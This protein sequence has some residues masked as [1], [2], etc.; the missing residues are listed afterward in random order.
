ME[1]T[2]VRWVYF[3][4]FIVLGLTVPASAGISLRF[5]PAFL[6]PA[7][8]G[9][10]VQ[11]AIVLRADAGHSFL[12]T[13]LQGPASVR[14]SPA[15]RSVALPAMSD[16]PLFFRLTFSADLESATFAA[17]INQR[18]V[19][20]LDLGSAYDLEAIGW[21]GQL[22]RHGVGED[23]G[24]MDPDYDDRGWT[25]Y[26]LPAMWNDTGV[27]WL[28]AHLHVP[29][30]WRG[31][32][33]TVRLAA[34][35]DR[36]VC[37]W[38]GHRIGATDGWDLPREYPVDD[39]YIRF[40]AE[41]VLC[42]AIHNLMYGG[43]IYRSPNVTG[44][45]LPD[46]PPRERARLAPPGPVAPPLPLRA[47]RVENG[48]LLY[49]DGG[50]VALWGVN[51]YPQSWYPY[52]HLKRLGIDPHVAIDHDLEDML[53]MGVEVIRIHVF[54]REISD[55]TGTLLDNEHLEL[56]DYL[57]AEGTRRGLYFFFTPIAWWWGP[58]QNP[59]SFSARTPKEF[60]W[61]DESAIAAQTRYVQQWLEHPNRYTG[62]AYKDE[63]AI[64]VFEI[65]NEPAYLDYNMLFDATKS[66]YATDEGQLLPFKRRMIER[67]EKWC[68]ERGV[69]AEKRLFP[70][71]RYHVLREYL[72]TMYYTMR[73][74]GAQQPIGVSL[75]DTTGHDDLIAAIAD[76]PCE[77][78]VTGLYTGTWDRV[79]DGVNYLEQT[80]NESLDARLNRKARV[81]YEFDGIK[82]FGRYL[83]PAFARRFRHMGVQVCCMFQYDS[84][85][86]AEWNVDWDAHYLNWLYTPNKA[87]SFQIAGLLFRH[88]ERGALYPDTGDEQRWGVC[89]VS[90]PRNTSVYVGE[91]RVFWA[92]PD[93]GWRPLSLPAQ[94]EQVVAVGDS[95]YTCYEGCGAYTLQLDYED[96]GAT[97]DINPDAV[98]VGDPWHP[99]LE[100]SAVVLRHATYPF[101]ILVEGVKIRTVTQTE[102]EVSVPCSDNTF[103]VSPGRYKLTW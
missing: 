17:F 13:A 1:H 63:P 4:P 10:Q 57:I 50:E 92:A 48:V 15:T 12:T 34:V 14:I 77:M 64:C 33:T 40:G 22:D 75:F 27:T 45:A 54:D 80:R 11:L 39:G 51:Y 60:M 35:D 25:P 94:P 28:R 7:K 66:Y 58:D 95:P 41:N 67:W 102:G 81:V 71:F 29:E 24:W 38:N 87:V 56:L 5:L 90:F 62:R 73:A 30:T 49:E 9:A 69:R 59:E 19:A 72:E 103:C 31:R 101:T 93:D 42:V 89:A 44:V 86:T 8:A 99:S 74:T 32:G 2:A 26:V 68:E 36:D 70:L 65:M 79:G 78:V 46:P 37:Y 55:A 83:Y 52:T 61:C 84:R 98:V 53:H 100:R 76:S 18:Q 23:E 91:R 82:T 88:L 16:V 6:P 47:M 21:R 20:L 43:G 85:Y 97:L 96:R 3:T